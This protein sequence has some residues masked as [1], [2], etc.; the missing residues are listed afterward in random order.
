MYHSVPS[1]ICLALKIIFCSFSLKIFFSHYG[2]TLQL[3][4][5]L[6]SVRIE[7]DKDF[8]IKQQRKI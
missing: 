1:P 8:K 4:T 2:Y 6:Q 5:V 7:Q 3:E